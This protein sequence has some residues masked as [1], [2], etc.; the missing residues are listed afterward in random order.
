[1]VIRLNEIYIVDNRATIGD[2]PERNVYC[3]E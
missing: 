2:T 1:L 3:M